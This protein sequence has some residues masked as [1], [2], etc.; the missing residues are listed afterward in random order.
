MEMAIRYMNID[1]I[2]ALKG[3]EFTRVMSEWNKHGSDVNAN[4]IDALKKI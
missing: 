1:R 3:N 2:K 4:T